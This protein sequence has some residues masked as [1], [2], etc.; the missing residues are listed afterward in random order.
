ML[1]VPRLAT[2]ADRGVEV[3]RE[4]LVARAG[5][6]IGRGRGRGA[7]GLGFDE[8]V[9]AGDVLELGVG[10]EEEGCVVCVGDAARVEFLQVGDE[11]VD[12]LRVE[13]LQKAQSIST[14][15]ADIVGDA[16]CG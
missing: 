2:H 11:V 1:E 5:L 8:A 15:K 13:E 7:A 4:L 12:A 14:D 16:P 3:K 9:E 6:G 10:V